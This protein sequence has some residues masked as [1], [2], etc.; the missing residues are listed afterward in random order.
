MSFHGKYRLVVKAKNTN[1]RRHKIA[2]MALKA[3][4]GCL[5]SEAQGEDSTWLFTS[6]LPLLRCSNDAATGFE[7][8]RRWERELDKGSSSSWVISYKCVCTAKKVLEDNWIP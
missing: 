8:G 7:R 1:S 6:G 3:G 5:Q 2:Q 4:L